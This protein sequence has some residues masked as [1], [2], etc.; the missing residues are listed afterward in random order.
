MGESETSRRNE[1][2]AALLA[3][4]AP[5]LLRRIR[6][7]RGGRLAS[8]GTSD[9]YASVVRRAIVIERAEG[10]EALGGSLLEHPEGNRSI[11]DAMP[12]STA[13]S[14]GDSGMGVPRAGV[15]GA[16]SSPA[17][18]DVDAGHGAERDRAR[19]FWKLLHTL[20]DRVIVDAKRRAAA[21]QRVLRAV[22]AAKG[23]SAAP[24]PPDAALDAEARNR[25]LGL[26]DELGDADRELLFLRLSG[27]EWSEVAEQVGMTPANCRQRWHRLAEAVALAIDPR[28]PERGG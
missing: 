1:A 5:L 18:A 15:A 21:E 8:I 7:R 11:L 10:I 24:A 17:S 14:S 28:G 16:P 12:G 25:M 9:V 2:L 20:V 4:A 6:A 26:L 3:E 13:G 27:L 23:G 22:P 19:G